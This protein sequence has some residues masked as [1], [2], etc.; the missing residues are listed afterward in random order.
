MEQS[1]RTRAGATPRII[2]AAVLSAGCVLSLALNLPGQLSYDSIAQLHDGRFGVYNAWHPPIMAWILGIA[3]SILPGAG[4]FVVLDTLLI[5]GALIAILWLSAKPSWLAVA[6]AAICILLPQFLL[7]QGVVWKDVLFADSAIAGFVSIAHAGVRWRQSNQRSGLLCAGIVL[8]VLATLAR[9]NGAIV[10]VFGVATICALAAV[11][12]PSGTRTRTVLT[13][14]IGASMS[15]IA[16]V[17]VASLALAT[18]TPGESGAKAQFKL[19]ELYDIIGAVK[20]D[21]GLALNPIAHAN[22]DLDQLIRT[23]G[24][25][26]YT[27]QRNDTLAASADLQNE[28]TDTPFEIISTQ[29]RDLIVQHPLLYL[30]V[31]ARVFA[32]TLFTPD[33]TRCAPVFVGVEGPPRYMRD[34]NL[35]T[36]T[37]AQDAAL[38]SYATFLTHTP[39]FSH[40]TFAFVAL[41]VLVVL[42]RRREPADLALAFLLMSALA[43]TLSFFLISIACDYRYL[44]FLDLSAMAGA[45][46]LA[47]SRPKSA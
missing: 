39:A 12:S 43:F 36:R 16:L 41:V 23:D 34:L 14:G 6:V 32:W 4:L 35:S 3:D 13:F 37:R 45:L 24:V 42:L 11:M 5:F 29:W 10:L 18:R 9:Q 27:P 19:L 22:P 1:Q 26:L 40:L 31:R 17:L 21:P 20:A 33:I 7:Y 44:V 38:K 8:L 15:A 2:A 46:H 47:A 28:F 25:R 30:G